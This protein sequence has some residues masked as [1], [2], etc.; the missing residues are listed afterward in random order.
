MLRDDVGQCGLS[1][2][3]RA[4]EQGY[5]RQGGGVSGAALPPAPTKAAV[6]GDEHLQPANWA[7][8]LMHWFA[9]TQGEG[10]VTGG[11]RL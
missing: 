8:E 1:Q 6:Q 7:W 9:D 5:L 10:K 2:A 11:S 4:T 3:R